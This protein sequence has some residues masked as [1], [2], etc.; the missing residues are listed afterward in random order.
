MQQFAAKFS[1]GVQGYTYGVQKMFH[2][3]WVAKVFRWT[4]ERTAF[5]FFRHFSL[6]LLWFQGGARPSSWQ[7]PMFFSFV[8]SNDLLKN[9]PKICLKFTAS[10]QLI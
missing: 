2:P 1:A 7:A 9:L 5:Q 8:Y 10:T 4:F 6:V 3:K